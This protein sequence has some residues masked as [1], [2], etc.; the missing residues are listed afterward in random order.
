MLAESTHILDS[1]MNPHVIAADCTSTEAH[2]AHSG[3]FGSQLVTASWKISRAS[4]RRPARHCSSAS[5]CTGKAPYQILC[6]PR[7][8]S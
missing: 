5:A 6:I 3:A 1:I 8:V 7:C 4:S 2:A